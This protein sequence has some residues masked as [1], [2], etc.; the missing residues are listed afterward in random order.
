LSDRSAYDEVVTYDAVTSLPSD[1]PV[2]FVDMA[3]NSALRTTLHRHFGDQ[4]KYSGRIGLTHRSSSPDEPEL[5]GARPSSFFAPDQIRKRARELGPGGIDSRFGVV[6]S[7]FAPMLDRWLKVIEGR[8]EDAVRQVYLE[9]LSGHV[10]PEQGHI[11]S[12]TT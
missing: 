5:P 4:M 9:T 7:G 3:G 6:W 10:P 2:A 12:L 1:S 8:G 11:L